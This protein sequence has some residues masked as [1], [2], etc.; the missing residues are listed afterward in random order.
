MTLNNGAHR[1]TDSLWKM[2][3]PSI[4]IVRYEV[5]YIIECFFPEQVWKRHTP[6]PPRRTPAN[7]RNLVVFVRCALPSALA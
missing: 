1:P 7:T 5:G 4:C 6:T 3:S 2:E